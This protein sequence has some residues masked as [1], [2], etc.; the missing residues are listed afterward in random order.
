VSEAT[1]K[2]NIPTSETFERLPNG[3][4]QKVTKFKGG[5]ERRVNVFAEDHPEAKAPAKRKKED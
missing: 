4:V 5:G 2:P 1:F 3:E